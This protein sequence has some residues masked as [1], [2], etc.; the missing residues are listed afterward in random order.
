MPD[1]QVSFKFESADG[2]ETTKTFKGTFADHTT[3]VAATTALLN[4]LQA[5]TQA[6][7]TEQRLTE[8]ASI[9]GA[10]PGTASVFL[11]ASATIGLAGKPEKA[12]FIL[13]APA[14]TINPTGSVFDP[15]AA[16]WTALMANFVTGEWSISD[17]DHY[18]DT[19]GGKVAYYNSGET[20]F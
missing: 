8:V 20:N 7:I 15:T 6:H 10:A 13:P 2:G 19:D 3:A 1:Y 18:A 17:G 5:A 14:A 16:A 11:R 4:D 12:N 9:A